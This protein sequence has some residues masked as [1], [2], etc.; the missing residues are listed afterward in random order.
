MPQEKG[1]GLNFEVILRG[2][3]FRG[4]YLGNGFS[5]KAGVR[6]TRAPD[7]VI[8]EIGAADGLDSRKFLK[9]LGG[10]GRLIVIEP[11][12]RFSSQLE[13][14]VQENCQVFGVAIADEDGV[15]EFF[16]SNTPYSSSLKAP[17]TD[18]IA[19]TWPEI[20]F[21]SRAQVRTR[22]LDT[23]GEELGLGVVDLIWA[24]VQGAED[25]LISGG[26]KT[27]AQTRYLYT[28]FSEQEYYRGAMSLDQLKK[29]LGPD[30]VLMR[31]YQGDALFRNAQM[32]SSQRI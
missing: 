21:P 24:D 2:L 30:W 3:F 19:E 6:L 22:R 12:P 18:V 10:R 7:P 32:G 23:L 16:Q 1:G 20:E 9:E 26:R 14:L 15:M 8:L 25:M 31:K 27:L 17:N 11:D 13:S 28:E 29:A 5:P 4:H